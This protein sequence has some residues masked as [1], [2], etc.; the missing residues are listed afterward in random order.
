L[1]LGIRG[2]IGADSLTSPQVI[3]T[4]MVLGDI[5]F[6]GTADMANI[7]QVVATLT[8]R[9]DEIVEWSPLRYCAMRFATRISM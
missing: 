5:C 4:Q 6:R 2:Y 9:A 7:H 8:A 1:L 3:P